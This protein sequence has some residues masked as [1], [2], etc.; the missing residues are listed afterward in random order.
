MLKA[1]AGKIAFISLLVN[2]SANADYA[3]GCND[4]EYHQYMAEQFDRFDTKNRRLL[5]DTLSDYERSLA[6]S[7]NPYQVIG[8][9][10]RHL[11]YSAQF[12]TFDEVNAKIDRIF[13]HA[14]ELSKEQQIAGYV[15]DSF[16]SETH[17]V[18][19]ARAWLAYRQGK[20]E[21]AFKELL[22]SIEISDSAVLSA[23][24]PDFN[25][26]RQLYRDGHIEPV[27]AYINKTEDFWTGRRPDGLRH[28]W[29]EMINAECKIQF[30][31]FDAVKALELGLRV[32][33][34]NKDYGIGR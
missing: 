6:T 20:H 16:S 2:F 15:L 12:D 28:V 33:D 30:D 24:G 9:L 22:E 17:A 7:A 1:L 32:I 34:V 21:E 3:L 25:L 29:R 14:N 18:G 13:E 4:P 27:V 8:D 19:I 26:I 11:R 5:N 31:S 10:S 23:F